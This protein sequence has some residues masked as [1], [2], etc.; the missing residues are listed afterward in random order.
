M[1]NQLQDKRKN[2]PL[3]IISLVA[4]GILGNVL[5]EFYNEY[6]FNK[7]PLEISYS[8]WVDS[9]PKNKKIKLNDVEA[10]AVNSIYIEKLFKINSPNKVFIPLNL[11]S[12]E[13]ISNKTTIV[14]SVDKGPLYDMFLEIISRKDDD[15]IN[16]NLIHPNKYKISGPFMCYQN[17]TS[18]EYQLIKENGSILSN[19]FV[20]MELDGQF[21]YFSAFIPFL[22]FVLAVIVLTKE[23][24]IRYILK[25]NVSNK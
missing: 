6:Q 14:L 18:E 3:L 7:I 10:N 23:L 15:I 11:K 4:I 22:L 24:L 16:E 5:I 21:P 12:T 13:S 1:F 25:N 9:P 19:D 20:I 2:N 8:D 17:S